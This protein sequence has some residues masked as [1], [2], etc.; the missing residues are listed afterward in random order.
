M[1]K[2]LIFCICI[3]LVIITCIS[4]VPFSANIYETKVEVTSAAAMVVNLDTETVVYSKNIDKSRYTS[5]LCNL[6]T[7]I[8]VRNNVKDIETEIEIKQDV[9]DAVKN[10]DN[11]LSKF[12]GKKLS[13]EDLLHILMLT[14]GTDAA[15]VLADY[16]SKGDIN[17]FVDLMNKKAMSLGCTRT[18]FSSP[19]AVFDLSQVT[20]CS[21]MYNIIKAAYNTPDFKTISGKYEY[22]TVEIKDAKPEFKTTNSLINPDSPYYFKHTK[23]GKFGYDT[24]A[25]G[26]VAVTTTFNGTNYAC[27]VMG[28]SNDSEH[29]AFTETKQLLTWAYKGLGDKH[30][31]KKDKVLY[32]IPA[33]SAF[34]EVQVQLTTGKDIIRTV[35]I[36]YEDSKITYEFGDTW[37]MEPPIFVGQNMGTA[38]IYYDG[39]FFEEINLVSKSSVGVSM[40]DD[41]SGFFGAMVDS[42]ITEQVVK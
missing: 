11:T 7:Y 35:P 8:I 10:S 38:K 5:Y 28:A 14:N 23:S 36:D 34:G 27:I 42:T 19:G 12:V 24:L 26:N 20:T 40:Y 22:S 6:M 33:Q 17:A 3:V 9:L 31:I 30:I 1:K 2:K 39:K 15:Y 25:K 21:D 4:S 29:N 18:K 13:V 16:V 32:T 37:V 41:I